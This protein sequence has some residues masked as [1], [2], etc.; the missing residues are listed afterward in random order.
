MPVLRLVTIALTAVVAHI[1][2]LHDFG[3]CTVAL[4]AYA[5]ASSVSELGI[6]SCLTRADLDLDAMAPT[7][8]T[9]SM[10]SSA[11]LAGAMAFWHLTWLRRSGR[12][13]VL[14]RSG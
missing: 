8:V 6:A 12:W 13:T 10:T 3:V 1:L 2:A 4:T 5:I 11:I 7:M 9:V 14:T